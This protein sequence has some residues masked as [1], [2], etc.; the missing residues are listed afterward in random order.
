MTVSE[1]IIK[2]QSFENQNME[3]ILCDSQYG[4]SPLE[5]VF[6]NDC[7]IVLLDDQ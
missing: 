3:V 2:L 7:E 6:E 4:N 5:I 1:L